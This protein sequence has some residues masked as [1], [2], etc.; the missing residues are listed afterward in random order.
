MADAAP[1]ECPAEEAGQ[2][3]ADVF[4]EWGNLLGKLI[5]DAPDCAID[6][7]RPSGHSIGSRQQLICA[8]IPLL[9]APKTPQRS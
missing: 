3:L 5:A 4:N 6:G 9:P 1:M 8:N 7:G 2:A